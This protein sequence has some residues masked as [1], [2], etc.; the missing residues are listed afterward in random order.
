MRHKRIDS[1]VSESLAAA[2]VQYGR[3]LTLALELRILL[4]PHRN[5]VHVAATT[6]L[7]LCC[8]QL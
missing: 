2:R 5:K 8:T 1:W 6:F 3:V 7:T 4:E